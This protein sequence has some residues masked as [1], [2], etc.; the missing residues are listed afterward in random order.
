MKKR[1]IKKQQRVN[2]ANAKL[3]R[4]PKTPEG[5]EK[6]RWN[7]VTH[8]LLTKA[9]VLSM[10]DFNEDP[11]EYLFLLQELQKDWTPKGA[12]QEMLVEDIASIFWRRRRVL[13]VFGF[14]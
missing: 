11:Q 5:K 8:G 12:M 14:S 3:S 1:I 9:T 10:A 7:A 13:K 2:R 4:G 6:S